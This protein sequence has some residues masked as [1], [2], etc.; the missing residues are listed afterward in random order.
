MM[1]NLSG[2]VP[3]HD[4]RIGPADGKRAISR[5]PSERVQFGKMIVNPI[6]GN[7]FDILEHIRNSV[8][9]MEDSQKWT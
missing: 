1:L 9:G 6:A 5:L 3:F 2:D 4:I 7:G 8:F